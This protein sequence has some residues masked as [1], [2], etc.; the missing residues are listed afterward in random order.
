[1]DQESVHAVLTRFA[2]RAGQTHSPSTTPN[3]DDEHFITDN[4]KKE[5][6]IQL[7]C[8]MPSYLPIHTVGY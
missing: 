1:M 2:E 5:G 6:D 4:G 7:L 8:V 3:P